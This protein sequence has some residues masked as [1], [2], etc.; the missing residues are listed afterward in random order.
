MKYYNAE[1]KGKSIF[2]I[3]LIYYISMLLFCALRILVQ[4]GIFPDKLWVDILFS[5]FVQIGLLLIL[6]SILFC[7]L[8]KC[9]PS[10][11]IKD[12]N[13]NKVNY[14]VILISIVLGILCFII[15]I[16][17]SSLFNGVL[18]FTGYRFSSSGTADY[19]TLNFV[20]DI[21]TV[22]ILPAICEEF[23]HRGVLLQGIKHIGFKKAIIISSVLFGLVHFNIQQVSYAIVVG[24][25]LGFV[26]V[27]AKNIYPAMIIHFINNF[28][29]TY[30]SY[31]SH[32]DWIGGNILN[33]IQALLTSG[34]SLW[35][36]SISALILIAVVSLLF[37][38]VWLLYRQSIM[39]KVKK[40]IDKIYKGS[41]V[42]EKNQP[43]H[44]A[45]ERI[46][47]ELLEN[48]TL[49]NLTYKKMDS[50]IEI[51]M[52]KEKTRYLWR[53]KDKI[54][55]WASLILGALVTIFTYIWGLL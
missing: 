3:F 55:M 51:V 33:D 17:V 54:F 46:I 20:I 13:F 1:Q 6:P 22:A 4:L 24:L 29:S 7:V 40:A 5:C 28:I 21:L 49:L 35:I 52:P 41:K 36:F 16:A 8:F 43:I 30:I 15:N 34:K 45:E 27:V 31:A 11:L 39:R 48:N 53:S 2:K 38:F 37:F 12:C 14:K 10:R 25:I 32:N 23:I 18:T 42:F 47:R 19:S 9:K 26:S 44:F 50:P